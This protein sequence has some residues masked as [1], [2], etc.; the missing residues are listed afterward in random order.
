MA[1]VKEI[2][3]FRKSLEN[4]KVPILTL[5]KKWH[6]L[7]PDTA[8]TSAVRDSEKA[9][10]DLLKRQGKLVND[11]KDLKRIKSD[12]MQEI[13]DHMDAA[14]TNPSSGKKLEENQRLIIEINEKIESYDDE[15]LDI[16][17]SIKEANEILMLQSM[18]VCYG[19]LQENASGIRKIGEWIKQVRI[20]LKKN[21][22]RKQDME[23]KNAEIYSYM[24][25]I[26]G[27]EI[28]DL[29]DLEYKE[30]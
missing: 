9:L 11:I 18:D 26:L 5:D 15:L 19:I 7:I 14:D 2:E 23:Q 20:E 24:H 21:I 6:N 10:N 27:P 25:D 16:P 12:L 4:K 22:I 28:V 13:V 3:E 29:F 30:I 1:G 8:K 17:R